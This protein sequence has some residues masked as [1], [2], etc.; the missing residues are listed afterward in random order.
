M[1]I[2]IGLLVALFSTVRVTADD[3]GVTVGYGPGSLI[4]QK[5]EIERIAAVSAI[6]V[7]PLKW[8]GWGYRGSLRIIRRAAA[9][10]RGGPG[11][12]LDLRNGAVFVVTVDNPEQ[13]AAILTRSIQPTPRGHV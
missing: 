13:P 9:V 12:R 10:M 7:R 5:F 2:A 4:R 6:D 11:L 8:G 3:R 1:L